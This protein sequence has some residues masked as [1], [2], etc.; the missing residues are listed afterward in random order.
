MSIRKKHQELLRLQAAFEREADRFHDLSL[1]IFYLSQMRPP[2]NRLF[3]PDSHVIMLWQHYGDVGS[4]SEAEQL[5]ANLEQSDLDTIGV[6]GSELSCYAAIEGPEVGIFQRMGK[7]AGS[8]FS[9]KECDSIKK[10][11]VDDIM[12]NLKP[13][14]ER[15]LVFVQNAAPLA[16]WLN[17]VLQNL[18]KSHPVYLSEVK[19]ALDPFAASLSAID[20]MLQ[21]GTVTKDDYFEQTLEKIQFRVALSFPG[22]LRA[23]V[24]K[25]ASAI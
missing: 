23:F 21:S 3:Q 2:K 25:V 15:K 5:F 19:L 8:I 1:S 13:T 22:E 12:S 9:D 20:R 14:H 16:V 10:R 4:E 17:C 6:R 11:C 24:E 18:G 7:R